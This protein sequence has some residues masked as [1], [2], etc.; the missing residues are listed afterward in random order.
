V[1]PE[2]EA[3][4]VPLQVPLQEAEVDVAEED[5]GLGSEIETE[6][7]LVQLLA[8]V[9]VTEYV[10]EARLPMEDCVAPLLQL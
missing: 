2:E 1:P 5:S 3:D 8:S 4:K 10:P 9:T 7:E 6:A